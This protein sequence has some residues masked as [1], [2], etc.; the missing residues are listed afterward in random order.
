MLDDGE[1]VGDEQVRRAE[2]LL[3]VGE[4]VE[5]LCLNRDIEGGDGLVADDQLRAQG[6]GAG[7]ADT[8]ALTAGELVRVAV[9]VL[10]VEAHDVEK[11]RDVADALLPLGHEA[12]DDERLGDDLADGH[13]RVERGVRV[14]EDVLHVAAHRLEFLLLH[15][16]HV[17]TTEE[18][19]SRG[20]GREAHDAAA[21]R[22]LAAAGLAD[23]AEGLAGIDVKAHVLDGLDLL[24]LAAEDARVDGE[25][26]GEMLDVKQGFGHYSSPPFSA[27]SALTGATSVA[28]DFWA[29][30]RVRLV[31]GALA[32]T[33]SA[34]ML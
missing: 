8:L 1:V 16:G 7:D 21:G 25:L 27:T 22:R 18:D 10:G 33:K 31:A 14:L 11:G 24:L 15:L 12:V 23:E 32:L 26:L 4:K 3:K 5:D 30:L 20:W 19:G 6:E 9:D 29:A 17:V 28:A 13:A 2:L 34:S